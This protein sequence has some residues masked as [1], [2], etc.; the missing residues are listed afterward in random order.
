MR[1]TSAFASKRSIGLSVL[2]GLFFL[3]MPSTGFAQAGK[4]N[5]GG[6][7]LHLFRPAVDS[8]GHISVNGTE[9]LGH[10]DYSFGLVLDAGFQILSFRGFVNN[11]AVLASDAERQKHIVDALFTGTLQANVGLFNRMIIGLQL[12]FQAVVGSNITAPGV[13]NDSARPRGLDYQGLGDIHFHAKY[14]ILRADRDPVGLAALLRVGVPTGSTQEFAGEPGVSLWPT[15]ALELRPADILRIG[16]N[17]GYRFNSKDGVRFPIDGRTVPGTTNA[18]AAQF[19]AGQEGSN[20]KYDDLITFGVGASL[21]VLPSVDL[22]GEFYGNQIY[23]AF[24]DNGALAMETAAGL[25]V[26]VERNS[27]LFIGGGIGI[28]T[29]GFSTPLAR[30]IVSF[31]F[32]PSVRD[33]DG[34]GIKD[35]IDQCPDEPEDF[36]GFEDEDGCPD[37]DNDKDGIPDV[38]DD[39]PLIPEDMD[40]DHDEDGCPEGEEGDRD[41]DGILDSVDECPDD[42]ED[43]DGFE[44]EDGCPDPDNDQDGILDKDDS[45]PN[46]PEDK[47]G[48]EDEDGCPDPDNDKDRILD[49]DDSCPTKPETY[50]GFEDEDGCPDKGDVVVEEDRIMILQKIYFETDSAV[51]KKE[52][53][54]IVDALAATLTGNPQI[55]KIEIQ[56]HADERG[57][58]AYNIKLTRDRAASVKDA[59][60]ERGVDPGRLRSAGYGE[61]CPVDPAHNDEAWE[62]NRRVEFKILETDAGPTKVQ[63][64]CPA[65]RS[66]T[67]KR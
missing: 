13:Y 50:N 9:V 39:C 60:I 53:Y 46:D 52:S 51:I 19:V 59:M 47:D 34:D 36:D 21:R 66:L 43:F 3:S 8:K 44:D 17:L 7:D 56:G 25:K 64:A 49:V 29:D 10:L 63:V 65:G 32:E 30:G 11:D 48:F 55:V 31:I 12:P 23:N 67:P 4:L 37:P 15:L 41:G 16:F 26:F 6:M 20:L 18:T 24:G 57:G 5:G 35:D 61:R 27:F 28:P 22:V 62:K 33:R 40:G 42:P 54:P 38:D 58:D 2:V 45:C 14:R 1:V